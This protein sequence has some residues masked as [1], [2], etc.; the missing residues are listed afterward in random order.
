MHVA[1]NDDE[2]V[3]AIDKEKSIVALFVEVLKKEED[4]LIHGCIDDLDTL[5]SEKVQ[6]AEQLEAL[7]ELRIQY[8]LS[9]GYSSDKNG[10][11]SWLSKQTNVNVQAVWNELVELATTAKQ[12]NQVNGQVISAQQSHNQRAYHA[13]QS[14]AGNVS[15]Y[16]P[17][18]QTVA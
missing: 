11:Q 15:L 9:Q 18:G 13:L 2:L 16:G 3:A 10:M 12:I 7:A 4:A 1:Q 17:K 5:V 14:A 8:L 6:L